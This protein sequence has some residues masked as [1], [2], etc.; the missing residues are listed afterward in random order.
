MYANSCSSMT[1]STPAIFAIILVLAAA[2]TSLIFTRLV[3]S[4]SNDIPLDVESG[5]KNTITAGADMIPMKVESK[6]FSSLKRND[7]EGSSLSYL[8][9]S[10]IGKKKKS[11]L[12]PPLPLPPTPIHFSSSK[13]NPKLKIKKSRPQLGEHQTPSTLSL[14]LSESDPF[15]FVPT[16]SGLGEKEISESSIYS[17]VGDHSID[18]VGSG[19]SVDHA[20]EEGEVIT[21][22]K[23]N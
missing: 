22:G 4:K 16:P 12:P 19:W 9:H 20:Q 6:K 7:S 5:M 3:Y 2:L 15:L 17:E 10:H 14:P 13:K 18:S 1:V 21:F 23:R 8:S 11:P